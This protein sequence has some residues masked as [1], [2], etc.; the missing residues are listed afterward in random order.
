MKVQ[1]DGILIRWDMWL[2]DVTSNIEIAVV[3]P[4]SASTPPRTI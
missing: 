3:V 1:D 4:T 2:L